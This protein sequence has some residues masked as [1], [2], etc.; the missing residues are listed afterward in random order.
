[1]YKVVA[2]LGGSSA[3]PFPMTA[4]WKG[5]VGAIDDRFVG[6]KRGAL[7]SITVRRA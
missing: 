2:I 6:C 1:M 7:V 3:D 5:A 4:T